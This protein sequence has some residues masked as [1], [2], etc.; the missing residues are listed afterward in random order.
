M[1]YYDQHVHTYFSFDSDAQFEDYLAQTKQPLV[2]TDHLEFGNPD[3]DQRDDKPDYQA[4]KNRVD[5][6]AAQYP[7]A[8]LRG[9][10]VGYNP[11]RVAAIRAYLAA[12]DYDLTLLSFHHNGQFDYQDEH[13]LKQD[14]K[15]VVQNY[16]RNMLAGLR[17]FHEA[18][19][20][21]HFDYGLRILDVTP[22]E[23]AA[24]VGPELRTIFDIAVQYGLA[25]E[26]NTK[27]MYRWQDLPLYEYAIPLYLAAGGTRFTIGSDAHTSDAF[28]NHFDDAK[29]LLKRNQVTALTVYRKHEASSV[30]F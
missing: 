13:F 25:F 4:Y 17:D 6:L 9:V 8:I 20:L 15:T 16:Y 24:W 3:D 14:K 27:S 5:A 29:A 23:L 21:A 11:D 26:L 19:V 7:Q 2:T 10:E 1:T 22:D 18:D 28:Q 12:G 30:T